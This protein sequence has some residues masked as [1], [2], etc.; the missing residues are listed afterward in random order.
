MKNREIIENVW[1]I[2]PGDF[3]PKRQGWNLCEARPRALERKEAHGL[4]DMYVRLKQN[5]S[6]IQSLRYGF[7]SLLSDCMEF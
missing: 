1:K 3:R 6:S 2:L 4:Y 7:K 5:K